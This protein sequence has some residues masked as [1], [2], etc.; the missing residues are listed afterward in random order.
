MTNS[1]VVKIRITQ[2][3]KKKLQEIAAMEYRTFAEQCR[4]ILDEWVDKNYKNKK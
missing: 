4:R 2:K 3:T 1:K